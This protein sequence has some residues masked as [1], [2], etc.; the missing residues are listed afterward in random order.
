MTPSAQQA[1]L[2]CGLERCQAGEPVDCHP[3]HF[4]GPVSSQACL[5]AALLRQRCEPHRYEPLWRDVWEC[6]SLR[7]PTDQP[8]LGGGA[9]VNC[10]AQEEACGF[11]GF[12]Q[13]LVRS[14]D[15]LER[16]EDI[17]RLCAQA[18]R[19]GAEQGG[20]CLMSL[21]GLTPATGEQRV[22]EVSRCLERAGGHCPD[23]ERCLAPRDGLAHRLPPGD[24]CRQ[25]CG[26]CGEDAERCVEHC[27]ALRLSL[28]VGQGLE[29]SQC[30]SGSHCDEGWP[31]ARCLERVLPQTVHDCRGFEAE[32]SA[33]CG[34]SGT[35]VMV[36]SA[37]DRHLSCLLSGLRSGV[38]TGEELNEC[39]NRVGCVDDPVGRCLRGGA[40]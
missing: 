23:I 8:F 39:V 30:L 38:M 20:Q 18:D 15:Q 22:L 19:C 31:L 14:R 10:M 29:F 9:M 32:L 27:M 7:S 13:C 5:N 1:W 34:A 28:G 35:E 21:V 4:M 26:G 25:A 40:H 37:Q 6:E 24:P 2:R 11:A 12:Y 17:R 16:G 3:A 33:R 36:G